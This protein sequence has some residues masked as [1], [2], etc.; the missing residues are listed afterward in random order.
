MVR[1]TLE[2]ALA[3]PA[4]SG[5]DP[6]RILKIHLKNVAPDEL[7]A[8]EGFEVIAQEDD[9]HVILFATEDGLREFTSRLQRVQRGHHATREDLLFA[10]QAFEAVTRDDRTGR[11]LRVEGLPR[12]R[13]FIVDV[14]LW[15]VDARER[16]LMLDAFKNE[17]RHVHAEILDTVNQPSVVLCR[18][19]TNRHGVEQ[20]LD[21][22]DVRLIDLPPRYQLDPQFARIPLG[23]FPPIATPGE[24]SPGIAVLDSGIAAGHPLLAPA[25]GDAQDFTNDGAGAEDR[26]GHGTMVAGLALYQDVARCAERREFVPQLRLFSGRVYDERAQDDLEFLENRVIRAVRY[27]IDEYECRIFNLSFGDARKPYLGRH[28]GPLAAVLDTLARELDILFVVSA[29]NYLGSDGGPD[30][31]RA[32][33]PDY[34]RSDDAHIIDP[35]SAL[36]VLT[37]GSL[38]RYE[39]SHMAARF[40]HDPAHQPIARVNQPSPFSRTGPGPRGAIKPELVEF[41]GNWHVDL[42]VNNGR[43]PEMNATDL[44]EMSLAHDFAARGLFSR[45]CGT[46]YAAPAVAHMAA[47]LLRVYPSASTNLLRALLVAHARVPTEVTELLQEH[48]AEHVGYG[49]SNFDAAASSSE[50]RV[51]LLAESTIG[52]DQSHFYELPFP[53]DFLDGP[54]RR[55]RRVTIALSYLSD[56]RNTRLRGRASEM[57]FRVVKGTVDDAARVYRRTSKAEREAALPESGSFVPSITQ[58]SKGTVQAGTWTIKQIDRRWKDD[59][60]LVVT[61]ARAPWNRAATGDDKYAIV[62]VIEDSK[63]GVQLYSQLRQ[64]Y[65]QAISSRVRVRR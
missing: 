51:T 47:N 45:G 53:D 28:V 23:D 36:N 5:F 6:R 57:E 44:A 30:D 35:A 27:F 10:V 34:L 55:W 11:A 17:V 2:A 64:R 22:R 41:G 16:A 21:N 19:R 15:P 12:S 29:G 50:Q 62:V 59:H 65:Q 39:V 8:I 61:N 60:C 13:D 32:D 25:V 18:V 7:R 63:E 1:E 56:M 38:A 43:T 33:Y 37:V 42:R 48:A 3:Q 20:L 9:E 58:R 49:R 54:A 46:S 26:N 4:Q 52:L 24:G 40:P 31:W 14:E